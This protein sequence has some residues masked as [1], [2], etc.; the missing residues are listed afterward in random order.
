[1]NDI[2][3][4]NDLSGLNGWLVLFQIYIIMAVASSL[5]AILLGLVLDSGAISKSYKPYYYAFM[6]GSFVIAL[7]CMIFFYRKKIVFRTLFIVYGVFTLISSVVYNL[8]GAEYSNSASL[9][10]YSSNVAT[11]IKGFGYVSL[12]IA[13]G[14][15]IA[16]IIAL[17]KSQ[18][19]K[20]TFGLEEKM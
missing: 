5:Q 13:A 18:R 17:F 20:N 4:R 6:A 9:G 8:Y 10:D 12:V 1:M 16:M 15:M 3:A 11:F 14:I 7:I 19:V 2:E